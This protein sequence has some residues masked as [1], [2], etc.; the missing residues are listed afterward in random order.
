MQLSEMMGRLIQGQPP[1][2][3]RAVPSQSPP[4]GDGP[5]SGP[6]SEPA[7]ASL[8]PQQSFAAPNQN[9]QDF[10][11]N[12]SSPLFE[13]PEFDA[14]SDAF[15]LNNWGSTIGPYD[16]GMLGEGMIADDSLFHAP[17][18]QRDFQF[19]NIDNFSS[20]QTMEDISNGVTYQ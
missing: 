7:S 14:N 10:M 4:S 15:M 6:S 1:S 2:S 12:F 19:S 11:Q 16:V 18:P 20:N 8:S 17:H 5:S 9:S 13:A 3:K